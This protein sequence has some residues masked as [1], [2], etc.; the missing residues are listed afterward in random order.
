MGADPASSQ[1]GN[2]AM[3]DAVEMGIHFPQSQL[4]GGLSHTCT[5]RA[6]HRRLTLLPG[7]FLPMGTHCFAHVTPSHVPTPPDIRIHIARQ[8]TSN[9]CIYFTR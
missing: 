5:H 8:Y 4:T 2:D 9:Y 7:D 6:T 3:G 1:C